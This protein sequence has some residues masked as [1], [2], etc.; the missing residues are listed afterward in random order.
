MSSKTNFFSLGVVSEVL[1]YFGITLSFIGN[2]IGMTLNYFKPIG[3]N[4]SKIVMVMSLILIVD[5]KNLLHRKFDTPLKTSGH[6]IGF[7][8]FTFLLTLF[9]GGQSR[10]YV[11]YMFH[12]SYVLLVAILIYTQRRRI[13]VDLLMLNIYLLTLVYIPL[14]SYWVNSGILNSWYTSENAIIEPFTV[15]KPL[16]FNGVC[17]LYFMCKKDFIIKAIALGTIFFDFIMMSSIGKRTPILSL[18]VC[19]LILLYRIKAWRVFF[20]P[21]VLIPVLLLGLLLFVFINNDTV[22][23]SNIKDVYDRSKVGIQALYGINGVYEQ[24][25]SYRPFLRMKAAEMIGQFSYFQYLFGAG[26]GTLYMDAPVL[27]AYLDMGIA[28]FCGYLYFVVVTPV[29]KSFKE[30]E[31]T[32]MIAAMFGFYIALTGFSYD[33]NYKFYNYTPMILYFYLNQKV[34]SNQIK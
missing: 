5:W 8:L 10:H 14:S 3:T 2:S 21:K 11:L 7:I 23:F 17:C 1:F 6:F 20:K 15:S 33:V 12:M 19:V 26:V 18:L 28:G 29:C 4:W 31:I 13:N 25:A 16:F 34:S 22:Y 9:T 30:K 24:S 27:Q 32:L